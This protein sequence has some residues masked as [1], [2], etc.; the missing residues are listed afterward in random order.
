LETEK[1]FL[2]HL[3]LTIPDNTDEFSHNMFSGPLSVNW[4]YYVHCFF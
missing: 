2:G 1:S 4:F 3:F